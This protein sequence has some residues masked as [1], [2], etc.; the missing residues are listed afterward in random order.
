MV[1]EQL[2]CFREEDLRQFETGKIAPYI[3]P[4]D[5][6]TAHAD[7]TPH[8]ITRIFG[9]NPNGLFLV[10]HRAASR[11]SNPNKYTDSASGHVTYDAKLDFEKIEDNA[12]REMEEEMGVLPLV[13]KFRDNQYHAGEKE[14]AYQFLAVLPSVI[15]P[16]LAEV[17]EKSQF[18]SEDDL[19]VMLD[20]EEF[21]EEVADTWRAILDGGE[22]EQLLEKFFEI[23]GKAGTNSGSDD[24]ASHLWDYAGLFI[25]RFQP[26]H[27]GHFQMVEWILDQHPRIIIGIGSAQ[28]TRTRENP[29]SAE[30]REK[31]I[32]NSLLEAGISKEEFEI[33]KI[34]DEHDA[35]RWVEKIKESLGDERVVFYSNSDWTRTLFRDQGIPVGEKRFFEFDRLNGTN[36]RQNIVEEKNWKSLL[37]PAVQEF[38]RERGLEIIEDLFADGRD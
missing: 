36:I 8:L 30:E 28:A 22:L 15:S 12:K 17:S 38:M 23:N 11:P 24:S 32:R 27:L 37:P 3:F 21:I 7:G 33:R 9:I 6:D 31:F 10:Q 19:R 16:N 4:K 5:R 26:F 14:L 20:R 1:G 29:F 34:P 2:A 35:R 18:L 13:M 25:G